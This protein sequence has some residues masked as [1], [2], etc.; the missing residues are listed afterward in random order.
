VK[1]LLSQRG[2]ELEERDFFNEPFTVD[3]LGALLGDT[4]PSEIFSWRSPS[5]KKMNL[6]RDEL[7]DEDLIRLMVEE[8]R[9]VRR[10]LVEVDGRLVVGTAKNA[11]S[12]EFS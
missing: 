12:G 2:I 7:S 3:E 11:A 5:V 9:L 8:P 10:P 4:P 1:A 6:N